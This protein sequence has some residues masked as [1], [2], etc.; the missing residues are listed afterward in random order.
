[1]T[2]RKHGSE[3][4]NVGNTWKNSAKPH[5]GTYV[6]GWPCACGSR[7]YKTRDMAKTVVK[8]MKRK[9]DFSP[10]N[11]LDA[12]QCQTDPDFYHVGPRPTSEMAPNLNDPKNWSDS[13][14]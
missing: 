9:G 13:D 6:R 3:Q 2:K 14:V 7:G 8:E 12:Y 11:R 1:M 4:D 5:T 10:Y